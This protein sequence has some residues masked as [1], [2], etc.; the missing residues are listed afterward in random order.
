V[1]GDTRV[2]VVDDAASSD[3]VEARLEESLGGVDVVTKADT[4]AA[5]E[6]LREFGPTIDCVVSDHGREGRDAGELLDAVADRAGD[7]PVVVFAAEIEGLTPERTGRAAAIIRRSAGDVDPDTDY[8][9]TPPRLDAL[10]NRVVTALRRAER[11]Q[12]LAESNAYLDAIH[13]TAIDIL[14]ADSVGAVCRRTVDAAHEAL[15][16]ERCAVALAQG[17]RLVAEVATETEEGTS[18]DACHVSEGIAG[19]TYRTGET[20][21]VRDMSD[22]PDAL[23]EEYSPRTSAI[24]VPVGDHGV[25]Q[26]IFNSVEP[27]DRVD[28]TFVEI[29]VH[30]AETALDHIE[31]QRRL[32]DERDRHSILFARAPQP[33]AYLEREDGDLVVREVNVAYEETF[34]RDR[35][36]V[37]GQNAGQAVPQADSFPAHGNADCGTVSQSTPEGSREFDL[38][39]LPV[40]V[41]VGDGVYAV[42]SPA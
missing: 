30:Y 39:L 19:R 18:I 21:L 36:V 26:V 42:Y 4:A 1:N 34:G 11:E 2:L 12:E 35:V 3:A 5:I 9:A 17:D 33:M 22:D 29:L 25:F 38:T 24:S 28:P 41:G 16:F 7:L 13:E 37:V 8:G 15:A 32:R 27:F 23:R 20:Q 6:Y 31:R 10:T 40:D 14:E